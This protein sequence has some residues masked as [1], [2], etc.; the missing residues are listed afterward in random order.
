LG[1]APV[2]QGVSHPGQTGITRMWI[3]FRSARYC[4]RKVN[5]GRVSGDSPGK[6][7]KLKIES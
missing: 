2:R 1:Q 6:S 7:R 3:W 4:W 5:A